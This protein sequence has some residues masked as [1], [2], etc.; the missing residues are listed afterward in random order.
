MRK[1]EEPRNKGQMMEER[2][3]ARLPMGLF[4]INVETGEV[5]TKD[6]VN[7]P[8]LIKKDGPGLSAGGEVGSSRGICRFE[9]A[10]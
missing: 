1:L 3:A 9:R 7:P 5:K 10:D 4:T 8:R 2:W 6:P